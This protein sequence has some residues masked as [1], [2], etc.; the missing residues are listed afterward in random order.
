M[1]KL[2]LDTLQYWVKGGWLL[3]AI[4]LVCFFIWFYFIRLNQSLKMKLSLTDEK[5]HELEEKIATKKR[6][7]SLRKSLGKEPFYF[8]NIIIYA[9][10]KIEEGVQPSAVFEEVWHKEMTP[11]YRTVTIVKVLVAAAPLLGLLGTVL[12]MIE[13]FDAIA[14]RS[15]ETTELMAS[16]V[17][18]AMI[19]T[20][21]GLIVAIPGLFGIDVIKKKMDKL[22]H[23]LW[24]MQLHLSMALKRSSL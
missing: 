14:E 17:S 12:G 7:K 24:A 15:R 8:G 19:T 5:Q 9:L 11:Y 23:H 22:Q 13:T 6:W 4:A 21:F 18:Q 16:G 10:D 20:Q 2:L 1:M 3:L